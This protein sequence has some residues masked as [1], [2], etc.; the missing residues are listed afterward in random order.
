LYE[1]NQSTNELQD[2][3]ISTSVLAAGE[4]IESAMV[5]ATG[6]RRPS[7]HHAINVFSNLKATAAY[8]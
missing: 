5:K 7:A 1:N 3:S 6:M 4:V 8:I 2:L